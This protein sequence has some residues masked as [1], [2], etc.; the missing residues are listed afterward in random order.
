MYVPTKEQHDICYN[1]KMADP[2]TENE[3]GVISTPK[4][5]LE[6]NSHRPRWDYT[7]QVEERSGQI[8]IE[9]K[10]PDGKLEKIGY[11]EDR[12]LIGRDRPIDKGVYLVAGYGEAVVVDGEK[13][14]QLKQ[15]YDKL[16]SELEEKASKSNKPLNQIVLRG[17]YQRAVD[18]LKYDEREVERINE[19]YGIQFTTEHPQKISLTVY[20][21]EG[22]GVC[23]H[24]ALLAG[25]FLEQFKKDGV[26]RGLVSVDRNWAEGTSGHVWVRYVNS[27]GEVFILD[28]ANK[29]IGLLKDIKEDFP[30]F[31]KRDVDK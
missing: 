30:W 28:P 2:N 13:Y 5:P 3:I 26:I 11:Y 10:G 25:Y 12:R 17:A 27:I 8:F 18:L 14:P 23:R 1:L 29:Y 31:Y 15:E 7:S 20:L 16:K 4:M 22:V 19:K 9:E 21:E 6:S 24:Q